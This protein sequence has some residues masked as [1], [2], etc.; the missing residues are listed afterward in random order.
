MVEEFWCGTPHVKEQIKLHPGDELASLSKGGKYLS[1]E[2][3]IWAPIG[4]GR[5]EVD[6]CEA[7]YYSWE[8]FPKSLKDVI[9]NDPDWRE[10]EDIEVVYEP[11]IRVSLEDEDGSEIYSRC[12]EED[13]EQLLMNGTED[14][15]RRFMQEEMNHGLK[16]ATA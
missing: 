8:E 4:A 7:P 13:E 14:K 3:N 10:H 11:F 9:L 2:V 1:A 12:L 16:G 15:I 6:F 5:V